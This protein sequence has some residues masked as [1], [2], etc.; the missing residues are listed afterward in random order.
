LKK[1]L[2]TTFALMLSLFLSA[3]TA[4]DRTQS[5][6]TYWE[7]WTNWHKSGERYLPDILT[8]E[9]HGKRFEIFMDN[10]DRITRHNAEGRSWTMGV[11]P[12]TD[13]T[14]QEFKDRV[15]T[16][17]CEDHFQS[18]AKINK[19]KAKLRKGR[20][21]VAVDTP[22][23]VDWRDSGAVTPVKNQG[24]CGSC[25]AF[26]TTGAIEG[27]YQIAKGTLNSLSEQELVDCDTGSNGCN[28]GSMDQ[29]FE[30]VQ[31]NGG[32]CL[33]SVYTYKG[34]DGTCMDST[35]KKYNAISGHNDVTMGSEYLKEAVAQ[36]PVSIAIEADQMSFQLYNGGVF[37]GDCG[38]GLDHGVLAVGY[39]TQD[40]Q[41]YWIVKNS[42]GSSWGDEGYMLM[43]R[44]CDKNGNDGQ[45]G[46]LEDASY[47]T[48][49]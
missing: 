20:R 42:W 45:C 15:V 5:A 43:C 28:G 1:L 9:E 23:S 25:W 39:G 10:V 6:E 49:N 40:G 27:R 22:S 24:S 29:G 41:D 2:A 46:I 47:P 12:F 31:D 19:A 16:D 36:G 11:T 32:L 4:A 33:D 8:V 21:R 18:K 44:N 35:C 34:V 48:I 17:V 26:S 7:L 38:T 30:W 13:M 3:A 37:D 14:P